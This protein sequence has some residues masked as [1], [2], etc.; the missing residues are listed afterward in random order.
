MNKNKEVIQS[1]KTLNVPVSLFFHKA[2][3]ENYLV[4]HY[5]EDRVVLYSDDE[6]QKF[7]LTY[8]IDVCTAGDYTEL[9]E[10]VKIK[11][12]EL[13]FI[14]TYDADVSDEKYYQRTLVFYTVV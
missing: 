6:E 5:D 8:Q 10:K 3:E 12:K 1:L 4:V 11:M 14:R 9:V 2:D 13:G 7:S